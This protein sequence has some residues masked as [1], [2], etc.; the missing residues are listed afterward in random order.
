MKLKHITCLLAF[1]PI[2]PILAHSQN[3]VPEPS[4]FDPITNWIDDRGESF[5]QDKIHVLDQGGIGFGTLDPKKVGKFDP[6][7]VSGITIHM[8]ND[9]RSPRSEAQPFH[10][11][12]TDANKGGESQ[13]SYEVD[14][15]LM[16]G[17]RIP[18]TWFGDEAFKWLKYDPKNRRTLL[19]VGAEW[20]V[21]NASSGPRDTRT[22]F[23][24]L[25]TQI[26]HLNNSSV[27]KNDP[28]DVLKIGGVYQEDRELGNE[29]WAMYIDWEPVIE[30][31]FGDLQLPGIKRS[32]GLTALGRKRFSGNASGEG[33]S[34]KSLASEQ[35]PKTANT[36]RAVKSIASGEVIEFGSRGSYFFLDPNLA[37]EI[38]DINWQDGFQHED[39][40]G[41]FLRG[42]VLTGV[43]LIGERFQI[44]YRAMAH[45]PLED[46]DQI[47]WHHRATAL[48]RPLIHKEIPLSLDISYTK[49]QDAPSFEDEEIWSVGL[50][51]KF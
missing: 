17:L 25:E 1:S 18:R 24:H 32:L 21:L 20:D 14:G 11:G 26:N 12:W 19:F 5:L 35:D 45:A 38:G 44:S 49:G 46:L 30:Q 40:H 34:Q 37:L 6:F 16:A 51:I 28:A 15:A 31:L 43:G 36:T 22:Y 3:G 10:L 23:G 7:P 33:G 29:R 48:F 41:H 47:F 27:G 50:G 9:Y 4:V 42:E 2:F 13:T 39:L 8:Q